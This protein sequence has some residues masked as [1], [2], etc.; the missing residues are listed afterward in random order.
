MNETNAK[1]AG[2]R[3]FLFLIATAAGFRRQS[4]RRPNRSARRAH[5]FIFA[6]AGVEDR[7]RPQT[8]FP[9]ARH[10]EG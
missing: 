8:T 3:V 7:G 10:P 6:L 1:R 4:S 2:C 5:C 9:M